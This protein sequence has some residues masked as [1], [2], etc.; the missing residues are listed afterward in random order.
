MSLNTFSV[1][2]LVAWLETQDPTTEYG[3]QSSND[4][5]L[6]RYLRAR[7]V[8]LSE[9]ASMGG[10][11]WWDRDGGIHRLPSSLRVLAHGSNYGEVLARA[12]ALL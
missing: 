12:K 9:T 10:S 2:G 6:C 4:C 1:E 5:L 3:Y 11:G 7:G 8:P